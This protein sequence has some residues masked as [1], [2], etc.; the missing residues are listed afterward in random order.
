MYRHATSKNLEK[1]YTK[2]S[3]DKLK[4]S[5]QKSERKCV[6]FLSW[7]VAWFYCLKWFFYTERLRDFCCPKLCVIFFVPR[8]CV[9]FFCSDRLRDFLFVPICFCPWRLRDFFVPRVCVIF[10]FLRGCMIYFGPKRLS[11]LFCP[12]RLHDLFCP[13]RLHDFFVPRSCLIFVVP[14]GC[15]LCWNCVPLSIC[16]FVPLS[17][18]SFVPLCLF[19]LVWGKEVIAWKRF[20][21]GWGD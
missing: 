7:E 9:T 15:V 17:L 21:I 18:C 14:R 16:P 1:N 13:K 6:I 8:G 5:W 3:C 12:K 4:M 19:G 2:V 10:L 11:D 20:R